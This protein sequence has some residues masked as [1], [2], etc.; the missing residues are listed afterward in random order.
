[1]P[2]KSSD[3]LLLSMDCMVPGGLEPPRRLA[4]A[5]FKSTSY[6]SRLTHSTAFTGSCIISRVWPVRFGEGRSG[7]DSH[8][9]VT[10]QRCARLVQLGAMS[11]LDW[12]VNSRSWQYR[13]WRWGSRRGVA[14]RWLIGLLLFRQ[15]N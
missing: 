1:M 15:P 8:E 14:V 10:I 12:R 11:G 3:K 13:L 9:L 5:D 6:I 7:P 2:G 4:P